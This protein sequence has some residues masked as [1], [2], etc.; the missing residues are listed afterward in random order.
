MPKTFDISMLQTMSSDH[1]KEM[2]DILTSGED[3]QNY[4]DFCTSIFAIKAMMDYFYTPDSRGNLPLMD[5]K[6]KMELFSLYGKAIEKAVPLLNDEAA[7]PAGIRM[8]SIVKEMLPLLHTDHMALE[9][10]GGAKSMPLPEIISKG[11]TRAIDLGQQPIKTEPGKAGFRLKTENNGEVTDGFFMPE[12][13]VDIKKSYGAFLDEMEK[14][15]A[16]E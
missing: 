7:G 2:S 5:E 9:M 16:P 6:Q 13:T 14:K 10:A 8:N 12:R 4:V 1:I 3:V 15:Y 11:R